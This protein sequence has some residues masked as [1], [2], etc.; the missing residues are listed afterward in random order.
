VEASDDVPDRTA[1]VELD[2]VGREARGGEGVAP[3]DLHEEAALVGEGLGH[4]EADGG[5][6]GRANVDE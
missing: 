1:V 5:D 6:L 3:V 2:E 4:D